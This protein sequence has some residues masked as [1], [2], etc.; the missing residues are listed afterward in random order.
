MEN[1]ESMAVPN[2]EPVKKNILRNKIKKLFYFGAAAVAGVGA[3]SAGLETNDK[4]DLVQKIESQKM[5]P[6]T[7]LVVESDKLLTLMVERDVEEIDFDVRYD[8]DINEILI[9]IQS[10][11]KILSDVF[12]KDYGDIANKI[13]ITRKFT[14]DDLVQLRDF[15]KSFNEKTKKDFLSPKIQPQKKDIHRPNGLIKYT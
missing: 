10:N 3:V 1:F 13:G 9:K 6:V 8:S 2:N 14:K 4:L 15:S 12:K 11:L 5:N 7:V